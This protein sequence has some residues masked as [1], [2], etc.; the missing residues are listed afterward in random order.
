MAFLLFQSVLVAAT[1]AAD[2]GEMRKTLPPEVTVL[3]VR[4]LDGRAWLATSDGAWRVERDGLHRVP[5]TAGQTVW[6][7]WKAAGSVWLVT[8]RGA[9]RLEGETLRR[10]PDEDLRAFGVH[11]AAGRAWVS[12]ETGT[13]LVEG[14]QVRNILPREAFVS[15]IRDLGSVTWI[16]TFTG[17]FRF[18]GKE[19]RP[20]LSTNTRKASLFPID[21]SVWVATP[22]GAVET[23]RG[24]VVRT[25]LAGKKIRTIVKA[26]RD[27]WFGTRDGAWR[28]RGNDFRQV[29]ALEDDPETDSASAGI[30]DVLPAKGGAW[31]LGEKLY[32]VRKD[33]IVRREDVDC[34][35]GGTARYVGNTLIVLSAEDDC[36][37]RIGKTTRKEDVDFLDGVPDIVILPGRK[38]LWVCKEEGIYGIGETV[39]RRYLEDTR[40]L[41]AVLVGEDLWCATLNG[42]YR[43]R[44]EKVER[45]PDL[46]CEFL[47]VET[48]EG[49]VWPLMYRGNLFRFG[50][51]CCTPLSTVPRGWEECGL[52]GGLCV[53]LRGTALSA[54]VRPKHPRD[55]DTDHLDFDIEFEF[56]MTNETSTPL[57]AIDAEQ[58]YEGTERTF[59][60]WIAGIHLASTREKALEGNYLDAPDYLFTW[61]EDER[62]PA[63]SHLRCRL[64][65]P[66]AP[67]D[68]TR[69]LNPGES[70]RFQETCLFRVHKNYLPVDLGGRAAGV[71]S[72]PLWARVV[73]DLWSSNLEF[74]HTMRMQVVLQRRWANQGVLLV[75][76]ALTSQPI[77]LDFNVLLKGS[78]APAPSHPSPSGSK[79]GD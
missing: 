14:D 36:I 52:I 39:T 40:I 18:D 77:P 54:A 62:T 7:L 26:G 33:E 65:Q 42:A 2:G 70:F 12:T 74:D 53:T 37:L 22:D 20:V 60:F 17:L 15:N 66:A 32:R 56:E 23:R 64:D 48:A 19:V 13:W 79:G 31:L 24:E 43:I 10:F 71:S 49:K 30:L 51:G 29:L 38:V 63:W 21:G 72:A 3:G 69:I 11:E 41:D 28:L 6:S 75:G 55:T 16:E 5:G 58:P 8:T 9:C 44:G 57:I 67:G 45:I 27:L 35:W 76:N 46:D 78:L 47:S 50:T 59:R 68:L 4:E 34:T 25:V 1:P 61:P 73:L